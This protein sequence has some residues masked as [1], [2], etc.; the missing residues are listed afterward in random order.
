M[1]I[2]EITT[3]SAPTVAKM[4]ARLVPEWWS[5]DSALKQITSADKIGWYM[6]EDAET[7]KDYICVKEIRE[8]SCAELENFG[9]DDNGEYTA[10]DDLAIL[11]DK[12][13]HYAL[14]KGFR[15]IRSRICDRRQ[16]RALAPDR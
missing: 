1:Q 8:Y 11:H 13:E 5:Y 16:I 7:A 3:D 9:Y 14:E 12:A 2:Y 4:M 15:M 6:G 10:G